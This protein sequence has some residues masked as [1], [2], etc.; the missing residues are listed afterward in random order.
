MAHYRIQTRL[1]KLFL[2]LLFLGLVPVACCREEKRDFASLRE[3]MLFMT[4]PA[5][6]SPVLIEGARTSAPELLVA[7]RLDVDLVAG[8]WG[9]SP[10]VSQAQAWQCEDGGMKGLKEKVAAVTLTS[11]NAFNGVPAGQSLETFVRCTGGYNRYSNLD[12]PLAQLAD[13]LSKW[14]APD[15][16]MPISLRIGPKPTG[17]TPQQFTLRIRTASGREL[18]KATP[19]II[20][21]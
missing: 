16:Y 7:V 15:L 8:T 17:G 14:Q 13:S 10:F 3:I 5:P 2:T 18:A 6:G 20:W 19:E 1:I 21:E 11:N 9:G 4:E 12:F